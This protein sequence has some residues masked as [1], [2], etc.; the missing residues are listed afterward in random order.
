[1]WGYR[2]LG[3]LCL[4]S[5]KN[6]IFDMDVAGIFLRTV[7]VLQLFVVLI[8]FFKYVLSFKLFLI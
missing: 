5:L 1:M 4:A 7:L 3:R 2:Y 8:T 6:I